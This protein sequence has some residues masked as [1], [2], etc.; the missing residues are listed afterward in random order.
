MH[1]RPRA[2]TDDGLR[3]S[4]RSLTKRWEKQKVIARIIDVISTFYA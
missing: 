2:R 4:K 3:D 1:D